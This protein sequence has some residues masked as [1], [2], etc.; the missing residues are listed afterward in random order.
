MMALLQRWNLALVAVLSCAVCLTAPHD[1]FADGSDDETYYSDGE[2]TAHNAML[3]SMIDPVAGGRE[4]VAR[5]DRFELLKNGVVYDTSTGLEWF[6][7]PD[8]DTTWDDAKSWVENLKADGGGWRM[9]TRQEVK[10]IYQ[11]GVGNRSLTLLFKMS[12]WWIWTGE[13]KEGWAAY[14]IAFDDGGVEGWRGRV[15]AG[16][17]RGFAVRYRKR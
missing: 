3:D 5:D 2:Q 6:G 8:R 11:K 12:G 1:A 9:P 13:T 17:A 10:A 15:G 14:A 16:S 7:G 4:V